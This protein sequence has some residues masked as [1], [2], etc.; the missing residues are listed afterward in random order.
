MITPNNVGLKT[1]TL[2]LTKRCNFDCIF[3][4]QC[5]SRKI[6][7]EDSNLGLGNVN[8]KSLR[9]IWGSN[10]YRYF[11]ENRGIPIDNPYRACKKIFMDR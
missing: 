4:G 9:E 1:I 8:I 10:K 5:R 7:K 2:Q 6:L 3:C 11:R